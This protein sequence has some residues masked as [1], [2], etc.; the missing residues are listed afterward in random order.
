MG[1]DTDQLGGLAQS[2]EERG[3]LGAPHRAR[4]VVILATDDR[5]AQGAL[6]GGMP[7]A[8]LCRVTRLTGR[9]ARMWTRPMAAD[10]A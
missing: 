7:P 4:A 6:G 3:D 5:P 2:V 10:A 8:G 9:I 1:I